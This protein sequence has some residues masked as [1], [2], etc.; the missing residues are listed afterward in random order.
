MSR[1]ST[2][3]YISFFLLAIPLIL[4]SC[5]SVEKKL[6]L[7]PVSEDFLSKVRYIITAEENRIFMELPPEARGKFIEDFWQRR[8]PTPGTER[9]EFKELYL[10]RIEEANR[11]FR[12]AKP[13]WLQDRGRIY[14]LF[15]PPHERQ[16]NPMGGRPMDAYE[17]PRSL[18]QSQRQATGEKPTEIWVYYNL[19]SHL[20]KP[21]EVRLIFVDIHGTGDY[22]LTT[23]LDETMPGSIHSMIQPN[24]YQ[25]HELSKEEAARQRRFARGELFNFFWEAIPTNDRSTGSNLTLRLQV[26]YKKMV[27]QV[28]EE[29]LEARLNLKIAVRNRQGEV[30]WSNELVYPIRIRESLLEANRDASYEI[31]VPVNIWLNKGEYAIYLRLANEIADQE[32]EKLIKVKI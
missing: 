16:V 18:L 13:G 15:G 9:N 1:P 10:K 11:L 28:T 6:A 3:M 14:I 5:A 26:P 22:V 19:F 24:I 30:V 17:D 2:K 29:N 23:D 21:Q 31:N 8:D 27:F 7:D 12:G 32:I 25:V 4:A 20:H